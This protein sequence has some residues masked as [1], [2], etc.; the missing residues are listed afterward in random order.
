L[1]PIGSFAVN[2]PATLAAAA[3]L[4]TAV[5]YA[6]TLIQ[7]AL[8]GPPNPALPSSLRD[9]TLR[10]TSVVTILTIAIL[11]LG[12]ASPGA[13][14]DADLVDDYRGLF[15]RRT[16]LALAFAAALLSLAGIPL[17]VG[18]IAKFYAVAAGVERGHGVLLGTL[19][20]GSI[21]GL[22]YHLRII[23]AMTAAAVAEPHSRAPSERR[24]RR[25]PLGHAVLA[26]LVLLLIGLGACPAPLL[27]LVRATASMVT[28]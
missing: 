20:A 10:E 24:M 23:V 5:I 19:V 4:V 13:G 18:F 2:A 27:T 14:R 15:W 28:H 9:L 6:L 17:I 11:W 12:L 8:H 25:E 22:Y 7:R 16:G 21:I 26:A 3:G 1:L